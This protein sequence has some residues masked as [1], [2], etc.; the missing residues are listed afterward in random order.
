MMALATLTLSTLALLLP[1]PP[2]LP[3]RGVAQPPTLRA[4]HPQLRTVESWLAASPP[5]DDI[6]GPVSEPLSTV[7]LAL[8]GACQQGALFFP[9]TRARPRTLTCRAR[10]ACSRQ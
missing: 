3:P 7:L 9:R 5:Y 6:G 1:L 4:P 2:Q 8:F 10:C